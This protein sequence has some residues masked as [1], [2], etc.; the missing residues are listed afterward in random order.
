MALPTVN[1]EEVNLSSTASAMGP[2][3]LRQR[4]VASRVLMERNWLGTSCN[5]TSPR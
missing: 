2:A 4:L 5:V 3:R 1:K